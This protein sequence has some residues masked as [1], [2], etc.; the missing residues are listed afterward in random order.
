MLYQGSSGQANGLTDMDLGGSR[1]T[2]GQ[3]CFHA[4]RKSPNL[5]GGRSDPSDRISCD[6]MP[7]YTV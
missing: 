1:M 6:I 5:Q 4:V 7:H 2:S 3:N